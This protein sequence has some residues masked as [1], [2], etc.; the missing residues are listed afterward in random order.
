M[1]GMIEMMNAHKILDEIR[2]GNRLF[3]R[4]G[5]RLEVKVK[6]HC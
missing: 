2:E 1:A 5:Y 3:Q 6:S 4:C